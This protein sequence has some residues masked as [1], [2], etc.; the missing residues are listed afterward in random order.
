MKVN[1]HFFLVY[2]VLTIDSNIGKL[3]L[4]YAVM[5]IVLFIKLGPFIKRQIKHAVFL[6]SFILPK[7]YSY[8]N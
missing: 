5:N 2:V 3:T 6:S 1:M 4:A 7:P 8:D